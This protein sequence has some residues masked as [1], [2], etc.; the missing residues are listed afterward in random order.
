M[1]ATLQYKADGNRLR[2][3]RM[4][5]R[6]SRVLILA[7]ALGAPIAATLIVAVGVGFGWMDYSQVPILLTVISLV[8]LNIPLS[9]ASR[10]LVGLR[11]NHLA[12]LLSSCAPLFIVVYVA[13]VVALSA[14]PGAIYIA[15]PLGNAV[16]SVATCVVVWRLLQFRLANVMSGMLSL[17]KHANDD[18]IFRTSMAMMVIMLASP[19]MLSAHRPVVAAFSSLSASAEYA[20]GSQV[21]APA[22]GVISTM[23]MTLW[24][25]RDRA[26]WLRGTRL[27]LVAGFA[28]AVG[29][30]IL[31]PVY[32]WFAAGD[33]EFV[34]W[35]VIAGFAVLLV[36]QAIAQ[37]ALM[38]L[39]EGR[40]LFWN[41]AVTGICGVTTLSASILAARHLGAVGPLIATVVTVSL[42]Q[43]LPAQRR[44]RKRGR[45]W[46]GNVDGDAPGA[47]G[48]VGV[49]VVQG[50]PSVS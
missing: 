14:S 23:S 47:S 21:Y 1:N 35:Q 24:G 8:C 42:L 25:E 22:L 29:V 3:A 30:T 41:A 18:P 26:R 20:L 50:P 6:V 11:K 15:W 46:T 39:N 31:T 2:L 17:R 4:L 27:V 34:S 33:L 13:I 19:L 40:D 43:A 49:R 36:V 32:A 5:M 10:V 9:L 37:P 45:R 28:A 12:V 48:D 7:G 38:V 44:V 16:A